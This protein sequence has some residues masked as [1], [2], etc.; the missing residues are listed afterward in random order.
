MYPQAI[1]GWI[2]IPEDVETLKVHADGE[3]VQV[4][5]I[6]VPHGSHQ[7][8]ATTASN[9]QMSKNPTL[10]V[11]LKMLT[12]PAHQLPHT[13]DESLQSQCGSAYAV[14]GFADL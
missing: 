12:W 10:C 11:A 8:P 2:R 6:S 4:S 14:A 5:R 3:D 7:W 1:V 9:R 13:C